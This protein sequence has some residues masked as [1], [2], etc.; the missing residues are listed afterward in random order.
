MLT[1]I[2]IRQEKFKDKPYKLSD[3][4][5][6][7]L[8]VSKAGKYWRMNYRFLGKQRTLS[9]GVYPEVTLPR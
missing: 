5:G 8:L 1:D 2:T 9:I 6:L 7:Y 3:S 4:H